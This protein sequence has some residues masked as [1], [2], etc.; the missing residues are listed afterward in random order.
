VGK[1]VVER[2]SREGKRSF[3]S[4]QWDG[5]E[6]G[7]LVGDANRSVC[8]AEPERWTLLRW[9]KIGNSRAGLAPDARF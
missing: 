5:E 3:E 9:M 1:T 6:R 2:K 7:A 8:S 4:G